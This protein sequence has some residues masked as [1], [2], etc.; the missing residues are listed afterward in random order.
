MGTVLFPYQM[1]R[2]RLIKRIDNY[3]YRAFA[4]GLLTVNELKELKQKVRDKNPRER[5]QQQ[6]R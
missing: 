4:A 2:M 6:P 5:R 1:E 3:I